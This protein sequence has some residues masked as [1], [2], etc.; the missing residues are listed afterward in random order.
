MNK[1]VTSCLVY[2]NC[3]VHIFFASRDINHLGDVSRYVRCQLV[4]RDYLTGRKSNIWF[5]VSGAF[6]V[7]LFSC[8]LHCIRAKTTRRQWRNKR[9]RNK[10]S[11]IR[12]SLD[13]IIFVDQLTINVSGYIV[14]MVNISTRKRY[15]DATVFVDQTTRYIFIYLQT[16]LDADKTIKNKIFLKN[17]SK[18]SGIP[19]F[20]TIPITVSS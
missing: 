8:C 17:I 13:Q 19:F 1:S 15:V 11:N 10:K 5:F 14:Q 12:F 7:L 4:Y 20:I 2:K 6:I 3:G 18:T 9:T 16:S